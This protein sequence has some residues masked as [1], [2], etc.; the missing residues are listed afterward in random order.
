[1]AGEYLDD[2]VE[3]VPLVEHEGKSGALLERVTLADGR[4]RIV[5]RFSPATDFLMA[6][7]GDV[8]G[9][10]YLVWSRGILDRLPPEVGHAVVDGW[11]DGDETVIV[12]RD[13][14][15]SV[16]TWHDRLTRD[17]CRSVLTSVAAQHRAFLGEAPERLT[18]LPDLLALFAPDRLAPFVGRSNPLAAIAIRGWEIFAETVP[19]DLADPVFALL[20]D[21]QPLAD[22]LARRPTTMVH[23]DLATVNMAIREGH[24]TLLD[25][26]MPAA[27][28]GALD[29]ARFV[30]GCSS[31]VDASREQIIADYADA[32]G[33]AYDEKA[34]R[35]SLLSALVWLGWNKALDAMEH[36][37]EAV[38]AREQEDL[39]WWLSQARRTL[40]SGLL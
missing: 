28:P 14:G 8:V 29:I 35:L 5:K 2:V 27:A 33:P 22:A 38:R 21:P 39:D 7:L 15:D 10:E 32:A 26:A 36:P 23:G 31:V 9:R 12:M 18:P 19:A 25:W 16:L 37:D 4:R 1:M 17:Q 3:R 30:A 6:G 24:L 11:V 20:A 13:L 34:M 40:D